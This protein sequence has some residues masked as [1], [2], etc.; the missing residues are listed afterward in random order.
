MSITDYIV[1]PIKPDD[2]FELIERLFYRTHFE[3]KQSRVGNHKTSYRRE[4]WKKLLFPNSVETKP[5][6]LKS[7]SLKGFVAEI[8]GVISAFAT[9]GISTESQNGYLEYGMN[10]DCGYMLKGLLECCGAVVKEAGGTRIYQITGM[11]LGQIRNDQITLWE[12][13]GFYC[14]PFYHVFVDNRKIGSWMPPENLDFSKIQVPSKAEVEEIS[15]ILEE[16]NEYFLA[17]E[18]RGNFAQLSPDHVFLC[19]Y[20]N[21]KEIKGISYYK[22]W[23]KE[24]DFFATA[25]GIHF[26]PKYEVSREDV[27]CLIQATL[28]SMQQIGVTAAWSRISSQNFNTILELSAEGFDLA[29]EHNVMMVKSV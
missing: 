19:L 18:F 20:N 1:R 11:P 28:I 12:S 24:G 8:D 16:D 13:H 3:G 2:D 25:F 22:V 17:E 5:T 15:A 6:V 14:N 10:K 29:S 23:A 4:N 21:E 26:R 7:L 27:R 9:I